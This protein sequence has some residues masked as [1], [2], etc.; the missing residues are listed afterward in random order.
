MDVIG[1]FLKDLHWTYFCLGCAVCWL[2]YQ[3]VL[4]R[5][6]YG[7][8]LTTIE[9]YQD[10]IGAF[11][12]ERALKNIGGQDLFFRL[13]TGPVVF[14]VM[15]F[16]LGFYF[17]VQH[18]ATVTDFKRQLGREDKELKGHV[19]ELRRRL[20]STES[21]NNLL[22]VRL[23][24]EKFTNR[25]REALFSTESGGFHVEKDLILVERVSHYGQDGK[26]AW[27][28]EIEGFMLSPGL[29]PTHLH[30]QLAK[31]DLS[32]PSD[33]KAVLKEVKDLQR[34]KVS[35][36]DVSFET[37]RFGHVSVDSFLTGV[38]PGMVQIHWAPMGEW[39]HPT[40][41]LLSLPKRAFVA[42]EASK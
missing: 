25:V 33:L 38:E 26:A 21:R 3:L 11:E 19:K 18:E 16:V 31:K 32:K 14:V 6:H 12:T 1:A 34:H 17:Q 42:S 9:E 7:E 29:R 22:T 8:K 20:R 36:F 5:W 13:V 30:V 40:D 37:K 2:A 39:E 35:S 27:S 15:T 41:V 28:G 24:R 10:S 23:S 4:A